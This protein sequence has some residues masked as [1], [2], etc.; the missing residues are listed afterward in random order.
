MR[1][2]WR[3]RIAAIM[4]VVE[5]LPL[6]PTTCTERKR[7]C[8]EPKHGHHA[9]H[10]VEAEAH[11]EQLQRAQVTLGLLAAPRSLG[12]PSGGARGHTPAARVA[13]AP[14]HSASSSSCRRASLARSPSTTSA[15]AFC[16]KPALASLP[17]TRAISPSSFARAAARR[18]SRRVEIEPLR[19][20]HLDGAARHRDRGH[21]WHAPVVVGTVS[22]I[23]PSEVGEDRGGGVVARARRCAPARSPRVTRSRESRQPRTSV[24][25]SIDALQLDLG[26]AVDQRGIC[27]ADSDCRRAARRN[28]LDT[29]TAPR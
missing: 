22:Q 19:G 10:P 9:P 14:A 28:D 5:V 2:P 15:G 7:R 29:T 21:R 25:A 12:W 13:A 17:S 16:T 6:V 20:E 23:E 4:R 8:G 26:V 11:P 18:R 24:T 27:A 1:S 3:S